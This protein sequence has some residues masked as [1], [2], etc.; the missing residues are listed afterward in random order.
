MQA[1]KATERPEIGFHSFV[2]SILDGDKW[3]AICLGLFSL[4]V[5]AE[6]GT[7]WVSQRVWMF[8]NIFLSLSEEEPRGSSQL[9]GHSTNYAVLGSIQNNSLIFN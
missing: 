1:T 6:Q 7:G 8:C 5:P 4:E 9:S 3:S 2:T